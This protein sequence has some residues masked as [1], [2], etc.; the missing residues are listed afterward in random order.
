MRTC[1][2]YSSTKFLHL[3]TKTKTKKFHF[4][5]FSEFETE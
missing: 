5:I 1:N 2:Q 3:A 4:E